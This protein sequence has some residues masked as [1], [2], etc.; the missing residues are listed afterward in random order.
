MTRDWAEA[1][2]FSST[3][4]NLGFLSGD[5]HEYPD[6]SL[7]QPGDV[8][9]FR[10]STSDVGNVDH[11]VTIEFEHTSGDLDLYVYDTAGGLIGESS[12]SSNVE[13]DQSK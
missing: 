6:L 9:W 3:A 5:G 10:L 4:Y 1:N 2:E 13:T 7:H 12:T 11:R 8:D